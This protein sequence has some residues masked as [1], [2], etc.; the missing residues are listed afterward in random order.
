MMTTAEAEV[1]SNRSLPP[2]GAS[3]TDH[4]YANGMEVGYR[5]CLYVIR[6]MAVTQDGLPEVVVADF[7]DK[8]H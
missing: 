4:A 1:P 2:M 3:G 8:N 6:Q 5:R 7:S